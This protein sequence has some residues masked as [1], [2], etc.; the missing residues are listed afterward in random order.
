ME[1]CIQSKRVFRGDR[2]EFLPS[3]V[4]L[5]INNSEEI[6]TAPSNNPLTLWR[7]GHLRAQYFKDLLQTAQR[8]GVALRLIGSGVARHLEV[9][10]CV[11]KARHDGPATGIEL[12]GG[13]RTGNDV[14]SAA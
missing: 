5:V 8:W 12:L 6:E 9:G 7:L 4:A 11:D 1:A 14:G 13:A 2:I 10:V 3:R